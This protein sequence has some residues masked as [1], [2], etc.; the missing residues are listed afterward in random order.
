M[1]RRPAPA[2]GRAAALSALFL[3]YQRGVHV[4][5]LL[6]GVA[7]DR[8]LDRRDAAFAMRLALGATVTS[9]A[10]DEVIDMHLDH[11]RRVSARVR[12]A[13]RIAAFELIYLE[14]PPA[15]AVSQGVE[16]VGS[17]AR[18]ATGLANAVLRRV[19]T[20]RRSYLAAADAPL[21]DRRVVSLARCA[22]MPVWLAG[23]IEGSLGPELAGRL[24]DTQLTAAPIAIH[25]NPLRESADFAKVL[26]SIELPGCAGPVPGPELLASSALERG[27]AVVSDAV[28]QL[29]ATAA[30]AVGTC[31]EIG[32]GRGT[33]TFVM[34]SQAHRAGFARHHV[35]LDIDSRRAESCG[36]RLRRAGLDEG[37]RTLVADGCDL[38]GALG[39]SDRRRLFETVFVDAPCSG[40]G[41]MRRHPEICW[42]L[43]PCDVERGLPD[44]Q[45][46]LLA[47]AASRV[48]M[49]GQLL[50]STCSVLSSENDDVIDDFLGGETGRAFRLDR[51]SAAPILRSAGFADAKR[52]A[53]TLESARGTLQSVPRTGD[54]DGHFCARLIRCHTADSL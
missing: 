19:A 24:F 26:G 22:G 51:V 38:E 30:T 4:R 12:I 40:T 23:A 6:D 33:K 36:Q 14:R 47:S 11:P 15:V 2:A 20:S 34:A 17:I 46:A 39:D 10:L 50:Y 37:V 41:T 13:L 29:I 32:S 43:R 1:M 35:A 5:E 48:A 18:S 9:G 31:L 45:R 54:F 21:K 27:D 28:A 44:L 16:L 25:L 3:A 53:E 49:G 7:R 52:F 42:R 8:H